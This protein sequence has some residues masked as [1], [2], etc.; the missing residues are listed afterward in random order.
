MTR[1]KGEATEGAPGLVCPAEARAM[2]LGPEPPRARCPH[3]GR[4][5]EARGVVVGGR[6]IWVSRE[7]CGCAGSLAAAEQERQ[8]ELEREAIARDER[9]SRC[10][11]GRRFRSALPSDATCAAFAM[12]YRHGSGEGLYIHG[13]VGTGKTYNAAGVASVLLDRGERVVFTTSIELFSAIQGT[14]DGSASAQTASVKRRYLACEVLVLDDLG[15]ESQSAWT[16]MTLFELLNARYEGMRS[17]VVTSQYT[18]GELERRLARRGE[19][20]TARA[21]VSRIRQTCEDVTLVG[22]DRRRPAGTP[23]RAPRSIY[24]GIP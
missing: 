9:L 8:A 14:F 16:L 12:G 7:R 19:S 6:V 20:E 3:C 17:T 13:G 23:P 2:G 18:M 1:E 21:V 5:L 10:G 4:E 24:D 11:I 22:Q 15:K